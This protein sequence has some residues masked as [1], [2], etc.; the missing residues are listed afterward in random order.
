MDEIIS[1]DYK[2]IRFN[3]KTLIV[4]IIL[5]TIILSS[6]FY[7]RKKVYVNINGN[8]T[9]IVTY[10]ST[11][12]D[13]LNSG[14]IKIFKKDKITPSLSYKIHKGEIINITRAVNVTIKL[15]SRELKIS[16]PEKNIASLLKAEGLYLNPKDKIEPSSDSPLKEG[17]KIVIKRVANKA[18][19]ETLPI[20]F[21]TVYKYDSSMP[22]TKKTILQEGVVG[23]KLVTTNI[24]YEDNIEVSRNILSE[25]VL[26]T[27]KDKIVVLGSYPLMPVSR[28]GDPIPYSSVIKVRATAYYA[29]SGIGKTY[30]ASGRKAVRDPNGYSTIAVDPRVISLG[31]KVFVEGYGYA[32][33]AETGTAILGNT[34]D[35]F[36]DTNK[37]ACNWAVKYVNL[38]ILK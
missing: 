14:K 11:V 4:F 18:L 37:E 38:Y 15:D 5:F 27:P 35:V 32:I 12:N 33:A 29:T 31:T 36:F 16:S 30:T 28:G 20:N 9:E 24:T 25:S 2:K 13:A 8:K 7:F 26:K 23:E 6:V 10:G 17:M 34:I 19:K 22:N 3:Y 21:N 1:F